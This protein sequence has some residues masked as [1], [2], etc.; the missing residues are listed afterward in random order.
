LPG[1][2]TSEVF[3]E[4]FLRRRSMRVES[5]GGLEEISATRSPSSTLHTQTLPAQSAPR[6]CSL[7]SVKL[8]RTVMSSILKDLSLLPS[9]FQT[10]MRLSRPA[11]TIL[12]SRL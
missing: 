5:F 3:S 8:A 10:V 11:E 7:S 4:I 6:T 1:F 9:P 2:S 12:P